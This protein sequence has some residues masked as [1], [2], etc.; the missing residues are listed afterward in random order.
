MKMENP[1]LNDPFSLLWQ[2]FLNL[3]PGKDCEVSWLPEIPADENGETGYG[4]TEFADGEKPR[5]VVSADLRVS[6]AIEVLA[7]ELAHVA[8]GIESEHGAAWQAA[9]EAIFQEYGRIA[10]E[11]FGKEGEKE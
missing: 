1:F 9:F 11:M 6:D 4:F 5:V 7:H 8:T 3:F 2:A 10:E